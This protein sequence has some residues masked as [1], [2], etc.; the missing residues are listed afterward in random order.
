MQPAAQAKPNK[1]PKVERV[2]GVQTSIT[3][4]TTQ[5]LELSGCV[6]AFVFFSEIVHPVTS[7]NVA[8]ERVHLRMMKSSMEGEEQLTRPCSRARADTHRATG[9]RPNLGVE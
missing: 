8:A 2:D 1:L 7:E 9:R 3:A 5:T 6:L 4:A